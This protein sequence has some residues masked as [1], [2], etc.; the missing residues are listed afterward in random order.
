MS[1]KEK[2]IVPLLVAAITGTIIYGT[3]NFF[4]TASDTSVN[5][6]NTSDASLRLT[7]SAQL[8]DGI[9]EGTAMGY[10]GPVTTR[11]TIKNG[12]IVKAEVV[13][14]NE[15]P[16][17]F[18][19]AEKILLSIVNANTYDVD[20][21]SGATVTC[22]AIKDGVHKAMLKALGKAKEA[23]NLKDKNLKYK[24]KQERFLRKNGFLVSLFGRKRRLPEI[25]S[26]SNDEV[27]Y[28][29]R[30]GLNFPCQS[31][32]SDMTLFGSILIYWA[33]RQG[34][35]PMMNEVATVHDAAYYYAK[36]NDI[37]IWTI[38]QM[39][40]TFR[41]PSTKPYF[42]FQIKDVDMDMDFNVGR[43]MAEELPF[44]PGYDYNKMLEPDFSVEEYM[45][46][47]KKYKDIV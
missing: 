41:N 4:G 15:T 11:I 37:N 35:L 23:E 12:K 13:S 14:H 42:G 34:K 16:E 36:P 31:A 9:Y 32:A 2:I 1:L 40:E 21:V 18:A 44:I 7:D 38:S 22:N 29:I 20:A 30:L 17:Y 5:A 27:A 43:T 19:Y 24:E 8:K 39:W 10:A 25:Y 47:H 28:A 6:G 3:F 26:S 46:E 45:Q 33:M